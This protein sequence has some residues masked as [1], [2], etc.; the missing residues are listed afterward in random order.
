MIGPVRPCNFGDSKFRF[1]VF[2]FQH[3]AEFTADVDAYLERVS[4]LPSGN[5]RS[6]KIALTQRTRSRTVK[7]GSWIRPLSSSIRSLK[8]RPMLSS[9][10][11]AW[12]TDRS[13]RSASAWRVCGTGPSSGSRPGA[14][15]SRKTAGRSRPGSRLS[16]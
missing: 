13:S 9:R 5:S 16:R 1:L 15:C 6:L 3:H 12:V 7:S 2:D 10:T 4:S 14:L 8:V 11:A